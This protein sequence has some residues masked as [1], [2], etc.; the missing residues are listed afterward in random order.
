MCM[1]D[2]VGVLIEKDGKILLV[3]EKRADVYGLWN[4]PAGHRDEGESEQETAIREGYEET[5]FKLKISDKI[6]T[7]PLKGN[8]QMHVYKAEII[9]GQINFD[10]EEL[11]DV[12][13]FDKGE[14]RNLSLREGFLRSV[15]DLVK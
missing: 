1:Q 13:W 5:G 9:S 12:R 2:V 6:G 11:L 10:K 7:F 15:D 4:L 14:V 8:K 3:Q